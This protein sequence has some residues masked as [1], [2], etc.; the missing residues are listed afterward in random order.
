MR[1]YQAQ[2]VGPEDSMDLAVFCY[3]FNSEDAV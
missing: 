1:K 2:H 3:L